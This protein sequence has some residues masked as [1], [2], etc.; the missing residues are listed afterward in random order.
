MSVSGSSSPTFV[1]RQLSE[2][3][4][5]A[6]NGRV[7]I[8]PP[9]LR[10]FFMQCVLHQQAPTRQDAAL[11]VRN[12]LERAHAPPRSRRRRPPR[13]HPR[14]RVGH[15]LTRTGSNIQIARASGKA[16]P[17]FSIASKALPQ[18]PFHLADQPAKGCDGVPE[19]TR[20][21]GDEPSAELVSPRR[22]PSCQLKLRPAATVCRHAPGARRAPGDPQA[23]ARRPPAALTPCKLETPET[24]ILSRREL[25]RAI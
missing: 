20:V 1:S 23:G 7:D 8:L 9:Y 10:P 11:P 16:L 19:G 13:P 6:S 12:G 25:K 18:E 15:V 3:P 4:S 2:S 5:H 24:K 21:P 14:L 17:L 22:R